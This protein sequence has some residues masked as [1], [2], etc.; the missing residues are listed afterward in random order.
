[1]SQVHHEPPSTRRLLKATAIAIAVAGVILV[2]TVLPAE[3]GVDPTGIGAR[4]GL[5][6]L[7]PRAGVAELPAA[8]TSKVSKPLPQ[9]DAGNQPRTGAEVAT[10]SKQASPYREE[11]LTLT[12]PPGEGAEIKAAMRAGDTLVFHWNATG[13]VEVDM[14][15]ERSGA[16]KDE[17]TSYWLESVQKQA[18]GTFTAP[19]DGSHGWFWLNRGKTPVTVQVKV[20]GFQEKL[21]RPGQQ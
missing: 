7:S 3:Y 4:L 17:Y 1:M 18:S 6:V 8:P 13:E 20:A 11:A 19:F 2:T 14:H 9:L 16:A 10:V 5:D 21:Y 15:G 12:L